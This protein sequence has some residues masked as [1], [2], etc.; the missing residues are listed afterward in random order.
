MTPGFVLENTSGGPVVTK[1][2]PGAP[3]SS[4]WT[5]LKIPYDE[6]IPI[7]TYRCSACGF[8]EMYARPEFRAQ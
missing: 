6:L 4:F 5:G 7:G 3:H 1:W 2:V 8:L